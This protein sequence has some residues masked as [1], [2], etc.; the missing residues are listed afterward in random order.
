MDNYYRVRKQKIE[1]CLKMVR[2]NISDL[3]TVKNSYLD[4]TIATVFVLQMAIFMHLMRVQFIT[5]ENCQRNWQLHKN[6]GNLPLK[7]KYVYIVKYKIQ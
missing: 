2:K 1:K 5:T 6:S 3:K 4:S 7:I